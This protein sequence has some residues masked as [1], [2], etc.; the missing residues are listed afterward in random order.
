MAIKTK[1]YK[2]GEKNVVKKKA[3]QLEGRLNRAARDINRAEA[4]NLSAGIQGLTDQLPRSYRQ[5]K[6]KAQVITE[7]RRRRQSGTRSET[8]TKTR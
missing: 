6:R 7:Q 3:V 4:D 1:K 2:S 5:Q 8:K